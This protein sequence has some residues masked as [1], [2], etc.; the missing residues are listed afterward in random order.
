MLYKQI[1]LQFAH[2]HAVGSRDRH[3]CTTYCSPE[4]FQHDEGNLSIVW[5][6]RKSLVW[7]F[8]QKKKD[9]E[10]SQQCF[11]THIRFFTKFEKLL[12]LPSS[13]CKIKMHICLF[14]FKSRVVILYSSFS[15]RIELNCNLSLVTKS[16]LSES[17]C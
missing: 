7:V 11:L 10:K 15:L 3:I 14:L 17:Q 5:P 16:A 4:S 2:T 13:L 9:G 12:L 6:P 1:V 8:T